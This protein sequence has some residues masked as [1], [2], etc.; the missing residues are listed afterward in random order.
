MGLVNDVPS[1]RNRKGFSR[2][3]GY[4]K[5]VCCVT[6]VEMEKVVLTLWEDL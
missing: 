1:S 2:G 3:L 5:S 4:L 6:A